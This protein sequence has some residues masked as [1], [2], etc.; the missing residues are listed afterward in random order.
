MEKLSI[1]KNEEGTLWKCPLTPLSRLVC[2]AEHILL[3]VKLEKKEAVLEK[4]PQYFQFYDLV[5][6]LGD[7]VQ[8]ELQLDRMYYQSDDLYRHLVET[9]LRAAVSVKKKALIEEYLEKS[10]RE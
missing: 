1:N 6:K 4:M 9:G 10:K 2:I 3:L 7:N 8:G 5:K